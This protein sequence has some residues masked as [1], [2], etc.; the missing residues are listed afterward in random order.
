MKIWSHRYELTPRADQSF[1]SEPRR[2]SLIKIE[3]VVGQ[4]GYS[5]LHP[6]PEFGDSPLESHLESLRDLQ[7]T[8]LASASVDFNY[9]DREF[10]LLKRNAFLGLMLPRAHRLVT[11]IATLTAA[12]IREWQGQGFTHLKVK[13]GRDLVQET[14]KLTEMMAVAPLQWRLDLNGRIAKTEFVEWWNKLD[15]TV[16]ARI[17]CVEDP[18]AEDVDLAIAGPWANDWK[19]FPR[20]PIR[21]A[22]PAREQ[23][24]VISPFERL[25]FTHSL[26]HAF[27]RACALWSAAKFYTNHPRRMEVCGLAAPDCYEPDV[28]DREWSCP[29]PRMKPTPGTGF[30]FDHLL[31]DLEWQPLL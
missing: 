18:I 14:A 11:D 4:V 13:L 5:D 21:I 29:G 9:Q 6:W 8:P 22:K 17:D 1:V 19:K 16:R 2:G 12:Q 25:I 26:E 27:G 20:A 23:V 28:F 24:E 31:K 10:R 7:F 3:W 15:K 30:G